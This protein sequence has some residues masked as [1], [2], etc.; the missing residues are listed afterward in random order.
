MKEK[1]LE[2]D[3]KKMLKGLKEMLEEAAE[4]FEFKPK[5]NISIKS[6]DDGETSHV[7]YEGK[8]VDLMFGLSELICSLVKE[9][10]IDR[11]DIDFCVRKAF[12]AIDDKE[13]E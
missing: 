8:K 9:T 3:L 4:G 11:D 6:N 13:E 2:K 10:S 5:F 7:H 1:D 12:E